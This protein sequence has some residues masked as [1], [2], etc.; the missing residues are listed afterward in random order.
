MP[1]PLRVAIVGAGPAGIYAADALLKSEVAAEPGVSID[2]FERMPAPFG[3]IRYGVAP[4]HPR[5][6]GIITALHQVLDKPQI[7]LF[8]NV[9]YP[10]D[11][12]LDEL[13]AFYDAV[14]FSTGATADRA[15]DIPGVDLDGS[16]GAA[17]FVSW[18]DGHPDVPRT[19]PLEAEKVAVLGVGNVALDVARILA[20][21]ADELLP[22]E[23][24]PNVYEGL[25]ANKALEVHVFGRRGPAQAKF[26]P[27]ELRELDHSP[28]IE[29]IVNPED[30]DYD[31]GSIATRR[32]N[33]QADMVAKTLEN[34]AI[35]DIGDRPHKLFLHF[36]ESPTEILGEDGKVVG[37]RTE[38]TELDGTG[39]V[40]G[41]GEFNDWDVQAR[42]PRGR[43]PL[44][45]A[46]QAALGRRVRHG[47]GRG[48]PRHRGD[49]RAP[50]VDVR[51]RLDPARSGRPDR[52]HQ[53]RRQRDRREPARRPRERPPARRPAAPAPEAVDA[54]LAERSVRYT[55]WEG[56]Y[57]LDA[58]EKALGEP[59]GRERV[60]IVER[61]DM[62]RAS[63]SAPLG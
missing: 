5:I 57:R 43:L 50:A 32:A 6:K 22:T 60:K 25:K 55:T 1:R 61:E 14:I 24:P 37:L 48:R 36:F 31:E 20:K 4:D 13:R 26:T 45:R 39:N 10:T 62:L 9:D 12:N 16:Y 7:R 51:H 56:W 38:R 2:L 63:G 33:K 49:R 29:V 15:L 44:R 58:A 34:W 41:T 23:I 30:I 27:M 18:Y 28:N 52:P 21:T 46:A 53:G 54:F 8:G 3:L 35:R 42:L 47:P 40:K 17:D 59:Q 11:I 19:W